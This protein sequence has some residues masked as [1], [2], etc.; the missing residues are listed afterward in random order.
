[1][2]KPVEDYINSVLR[3]RR[4]EFGGKAVCPF[5]GPELDSQKLM[6]AEVGEKNLDE[7]IDEFKASDHESAIFVMPEDIPAEETRNFQIFVN[8]LLAYKGMREYKNICF[9]PNDKVSVEGYNPRSLAPAFMINI[10]GREVLSK[11]AKSLTKTTYY[12][13]L[14]EDY[15]TFLKV[16]LPK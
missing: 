2:S 6:I 10:A 1:M 13:R 11:A 7:L 12:D 16:T 3:E 15:L 14:P 4:S 9:N 5:A 8:Q